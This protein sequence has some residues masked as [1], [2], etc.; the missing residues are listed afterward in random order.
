MRSAD[1]RPWFVGSGGACPNTGKVS[2]GQDYGINPDD[3]ALYGVLP[4]PLAGGPTDVCT[5]NSNCI[6]TTHCMCAPSD[7]TSSENGLDPNY[8][9]YLEGGTG[10]TSKTP[11]TRIKNVNDLAHAG[12]RWGLRKSSPDN[13]AK[14]WTR[15][16]RL[17]RSL[18]P[19]ECQNR[20]SMRVFSNDSPQVSTR[21]DWSVEKG[22]FEPS[23]PFISR[24]FLG[25]EG[26]SLGSTRLG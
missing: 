2:T 8:Y 24:S 21:R 14:F 17:T 1:A 7:A 13:F 18:D 25:F 5:N 22:G 11:D 10:L 4:A 3:K 20:A 9:Q 23:R 15:S 16:A 19:P 6:D 12:S 26:H